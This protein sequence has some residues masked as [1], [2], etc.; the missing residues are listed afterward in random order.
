MHTVSVCKSQRTIYNIIFSVFHLHYVPMSCSLTN[1]IADLDI[2]LFGLSTETWGLV[3]GFM[4]L[5]EIIIVVLVCSGFCSG[6][7]AR[8]DNPDIFPVRNLLFRYE[9]SL[10]FFQS[11]Y[12]RNEWMRIRPTKL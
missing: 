1:D 12:F 3:I 5:L 10:S 7:R 4:G 8:G 11:A 6:D 9:C 2:D